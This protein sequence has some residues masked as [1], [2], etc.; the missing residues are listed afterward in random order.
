MSETSPWPVTTIAQAHAQLTAPSARFDEE[1]FLVII[2]RARGMLI[3]GGENIYCVEV[4][5]VL[6]DHP[7][8]MDAALVGVLHGTIGEEPAAVAHLK[9]G[10]T[11]TQAE[12]KKV[13]EG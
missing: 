12:L 9:P 2:D 1:G 5:N 8:V 4:E 11:V 7:D 10:G 13:F 3:R 6:Y